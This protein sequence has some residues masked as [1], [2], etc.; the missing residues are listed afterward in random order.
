LLSEGNYPYDDVWPK[1]D[2]LFE[3]YGHERVMWGSDYTRLRIADRP[4]G[5]RPRR[6]GIR[7]G[8]KLYYQLHS[9][10]R[11]WEQKALVLGGNARRLFS[12]P[13]A[14]PNWGPPPMSW[15]Q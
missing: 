5:E 14:D 1:L 3:A 7:Y 15:P 4:L 10:R 6:R 12:L 2:R 8:E 13:P 9:D 11:T